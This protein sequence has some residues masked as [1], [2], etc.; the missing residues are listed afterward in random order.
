MCSYG[1]AHSLVCASQRP[2]A[3]SSARALKCA[4]GL[5]APRTRELLGRGCTCLEGA[6]SSVCAPKCQGAGSLVFTPSCASGAH[7]WEMCGC[8]G[9]ALA[10]RYDMHL[11]GWRTLLGVHSLMPMCVLVGRPTWCAVLSRARASCARISIDCSMF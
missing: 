2:Y 6:C 4:S 8:R 10:P 11:F 3:C 5:C 7:T 9:C 1:K